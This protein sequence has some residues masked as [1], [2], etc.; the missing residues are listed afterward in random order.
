MDAMTT[1]EVGTGTTTKTRMT[2][3]CLELQIDILVNQ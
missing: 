2:G 3:N 1:T